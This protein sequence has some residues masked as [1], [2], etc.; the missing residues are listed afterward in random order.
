MNLPI[1]VAVCGAL[2]R[3]GQRVVNAVRHHDR[4]DLTGA[5]E[6]PDHPG[7]GLDVGAQTGLGDIDVPV[8]GD[9]VQATSLAKVYIDFTTPEAVMANLEMAQN[10]GLAA[11][12]G[13]TGLD[14]AQQKSLAAFA[15]RMPIV[16]S[17]NMS[18]G[19]NLMFKVAQIMAKSLGPDF[20]IEIVEAH[21][22]L[23]KDAPSGTALKLHELV[24]GAKGLDPV[25]SMVTGR[26]GLVGAREDGEIGV[27]A[28][29]G[30]DIIG[31]HTVLFAGPGE[32]LELTHRAHSRDTFAAG[33]VRAAV[34]IFDKKPGLYSLTDVLGL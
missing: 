34:W 23:K 32:R 11:V 10:M 2:G 33:A 21:H 25:A 3:M 17:P 15:L 8:S 14:A 5:A 4:L 26:S 1:P 9:F 31:D 18:P 22:R 30:G 12:I 29:R 7:V 24:A 13:A 19:V 27:L 20:D 16:W 6:R 28:V